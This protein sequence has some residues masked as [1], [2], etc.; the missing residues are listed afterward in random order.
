[1]VV[2][3]ALSKIAGSSLHSEQN[4]KE[5]IESSMQDKNTFEKEPCPLP[6]KDKEC[7]ESPFGEREE[8]DLSRIASTI[9]IVFNNGS[10]YDVQDSISW[11]GSEG[12]DRS[13]EEE[14][15]TSI[16]SLDGPIVHNSPSAAPIDLLSATSLS[17]AILSLTSSKHSMQA[18]DEDDDE[19]SLPID[20]RE[21][22]QS[23]T[24]AIS[25]TKDDPP[26]FNLCL[27]TISLTSSFSIDTPIPSLLSPMEDDLDIEKVLQMIESGTQETKP[28]IDNKLDKEE[29]GAMHGL[30]GSCESDQD[31]Q[32]DPTRANAYSSKL[33]AEIKTRDTRDNNNNN[34][35]ENKPHQPNHGEEKSTKVS[36]K[37]QVF[38]QQEGYRRVGFA[39]DREVEKGQC[40]PSFA[41]RMERLHHQCSLLQ[42]V[43]HFIDNSCGL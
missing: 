32:V 21:S 37:R 7:R 36:P 10:D 39:H 30:V 4:I 24:E 14:E 25:S 3:D 31:Y 29:K 11:D 16:L 34:N 18:D 13:K 23:L 12:I 2:A 22:N 33:H 9:E 26:P 8:N 5:P 6:Q 27:S 1:M 38:L 40:V 43:E 15:E 35:E 19:N 17:Q 42:V 28:G 41:E 20:K